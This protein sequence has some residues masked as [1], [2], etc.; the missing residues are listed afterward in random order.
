MAEKDNKVDRVR[1][2]LEQVRESADAIVILAE[3]HPELRELLIGLLDQVINMGPSANLPVQR[4]AEKLAAAN[5]LL[6]TLVT[7]GR[8]DS[9][10]PDGLKAA[11]LGKVVASLEPKVRARN[12]EETAKYGPLEPLT[13]DAPIADWM[14]Q[15][16]RRDA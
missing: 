8:N 12:A 11:D 9:P 15:V 14:K 1:E 4:V 3:A 5:V 2:P 6:G 10:L 7:G 13:P 16:P